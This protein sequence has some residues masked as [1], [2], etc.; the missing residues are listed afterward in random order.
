MEYSKINYFEKTDSP[1]H[2]EFII[3]QNN[4]IL[5]GTVLELKHIADRSTGEIT[6]EAFCT[7]C[8]VKTRNKTHVLN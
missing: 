7:Q 6:E 5:C 1:K 8:E 2:R 3:S 4:C